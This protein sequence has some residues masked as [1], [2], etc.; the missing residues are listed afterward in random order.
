[1]ADFG[2]KLDDLLHYASG[3]HWMSG[4]V[5]MVRRISGICICALCDN[6][7]N[8][9]MDAGTGKEENRTKA[10]LSGYFYVFNI[11]GDRFFYSLLWDFSR[12][13]PV[14]SPVFIPTYVIAHFISSK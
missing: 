1:M 8:W 10:E 5:W 7:D 2:R 4:M 6:Y 9:K 11:R 13:F 3:N 14:G 12:I